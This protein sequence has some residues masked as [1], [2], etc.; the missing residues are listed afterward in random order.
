MSIKLW[1]K[2]NFKMTTMEQEIKEGLFCTKDLVWQHRC[3]TCES[4]KNASKIWALVA[5]S[6][7]DNLACAPTRV[8]T[9]APM[10][11]KIKCNQPPS[12]N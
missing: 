9:G 11:I 1:S 7:A 8:T 12:H 10:V 2:K 5:I 4:G 6:T 3:H